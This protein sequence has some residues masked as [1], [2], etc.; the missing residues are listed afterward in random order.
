MAIEIRFPTPAGQTSGAYYKIERKVGDFATACAGARIKLAADGSIEDA[1]V[2]IGAVGPKAM[3]VAE[4]EK[5]LRGAKPSKDVIKAAAD[6]ARKLAD[7]V[8][9]NRG[10]AEYKKDMAGVLVARA[11]QTTFQRLGVGGLA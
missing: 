11:L 8:A 5:L 6:A 4:A 9:D 1:G 7:P 2:A 10:S 3:R